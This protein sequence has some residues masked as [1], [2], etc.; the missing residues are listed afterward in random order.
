MFCI[1]DGKF[2]TNNSELYVTCLY[3]TF[4]EDCSLR[5]SHIDNG[6]TTLEGYA[7]QES[8]CGI[9]LTLKII[10]DGNGMV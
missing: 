8:L 9:V 6:N 2:Q 10:V 7:G 4:Y 3:T 5:C 1:R